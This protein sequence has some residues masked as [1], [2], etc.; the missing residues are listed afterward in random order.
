MSSV[1]LNLKGFLSDLLGAA[2]AGIQPCS[3]L[4]KMQLM[5]SPARAG[6]GTTKAEDGQLPQS[7]CYYST[8]KTRSPTP[9]ND[10][11]HRH[12]QG[13]VPAE[14]MSHQ[15]QPCDWEAFKAGLILQPGTGCHGEQERAGR[16]SLPSAV[17]LTLLHLPHPLHGY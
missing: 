10:T 7:H 3:P 4:S 14:P 12:I 15:N 1:A 6:G 17:A 13:L 5:L 2:V 8:P 11:G 16:P 9:N